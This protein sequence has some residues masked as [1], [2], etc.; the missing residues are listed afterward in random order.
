MILDAGAEH[1]FAVEPALGAFETLK[2]NTRDDADRIAYLNIPGDEIPANLDLDVI[3]SMGVVHHIPEP[4]PV[5]SAAYDALK[6]D[7]LCL[8]WL[9][10]K[11]GNELYLSLVNPLRYV[12]T[13]IP[14]F[15]LTLLCHVLNAVL[16]VY[17]LMCFVLPLPMRKYAKDVL[18]RLSHRKRHLVIYDQLNPAYAKYYTKDEA[19]DLFDR[20]GFKDIHL[21]HRHGYS[22]SVLGRK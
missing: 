15:L 16:F 19:K 17:I 21:H 7:G 14:H 13:R 10:G 22:W 2:A 20:A 18:W 12:T 1:V 8:L 4:D 9:Y 11:E 6:P 5:M 3:I